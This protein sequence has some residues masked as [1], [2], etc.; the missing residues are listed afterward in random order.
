MNVRMYKA[1]NILWKWWVCTVPR[2]DQDPPEILVCRCE[3]WLES[4][5]QVPGAD[6]EF[7]R[8]REPCMGLRENIGGS[9]ARQSLVQC[10]VYNCNAVRK[11]A[12]CVHPRTGERGITDQRRYQSL[13]TA[14]V[15]RPDGA[16]LRVPALLPLAGGFLAG[17][18]FVIFAGWLG[19]IELG[20]RKIRWAVNSGGWDLIE[21]YLRTAVRPFFLG[22]SISSISSSSSSLSSCN[23]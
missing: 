9:R 6:G 19:E 22:G 17:A 13:A 1:A 14:L 10:R 7:R 4:A 16:K 21:P 12:R 20:H 11:Y 18:F 3:R 15:L 5:L 8:G 23:Y 2:V